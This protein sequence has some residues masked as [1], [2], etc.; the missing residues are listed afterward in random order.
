MVLGPGHD[1]GYWL[2]ALRAEHPEL[3]AGMAWSTGNVLDAT[4]ARCVDLNLDVHGCSSRWR[5]IDTEDDIAALDDVLD[6][7]PGKRTSATRALP[8]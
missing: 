5:D 6:T 8:S 2:I 4:L 7:L 1:G 3:F